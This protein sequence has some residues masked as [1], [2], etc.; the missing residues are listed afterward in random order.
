[1]ADIFNRGSHALAIL[2]VATATGSLAAVRP[3]LQDLLP[4]TAAPEWPEPSVEWRNRLMAREPGSARLIAIVQAPWL[5]KPGMLWRSFFPPPEVL[6]SQ[7]SMLTCSSGDGA[8]STR[9]DG[10]DSSVQHRG[11]CAISADFGKPFRRRN[12]LCL[13]LICKVQL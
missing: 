5:E 2:D 7:T 12:C 11:S 4:H 10:Q 8:C 6:L 9:P 3:F 13:P 1:M